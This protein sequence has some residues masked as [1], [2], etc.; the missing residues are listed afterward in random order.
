MREGFWGNVQT[1]AA[2]G[3]QHPQTIIHP[4]AAARLAAVAYDVARLIFIREKRPE[5][6]LRADKGLMHP[7]G[8]C[9]C[10]RAWVAGLCAC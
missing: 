9:W 8:G 4:R 3:G 6:D 10:Q 5:T 2:G 7:V 1:G